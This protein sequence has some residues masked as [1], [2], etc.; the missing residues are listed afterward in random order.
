M[1]TQTQEVMRRRVHRIGAQHNRTAHRRPIGAA[2]ASPSP[3]AIAPRSAGASAALVFPPT[4]VE[5]RY[6]SPL[7][8]AVLIVGTFL[9]TL[10]GGVMLGLGLAN[11]WG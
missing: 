6:A 5:V 10:A 1:E 9:V 8:H 7:P 11:Y 2:A 3:T 4:E